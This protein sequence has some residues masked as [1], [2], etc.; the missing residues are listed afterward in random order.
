MS[1]KPILIDL[2]EVIET[3]RLLLKIP[4]AGYGP[5]LYEA[6]ADGYDDYVK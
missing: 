2:P 1:K 6:S 3:S 5:G 4:Q